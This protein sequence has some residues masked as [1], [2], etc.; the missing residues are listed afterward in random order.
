V[1]TAARTRHHRHTT[2][3]PLPT[4]TAV[5]HLLKPPAPLSRTLCQ[6]PSPCLSTSSI[7]SSFSSLLH[8]TG[9]RLAACCSS[10]LLPGLPITST[11]CCS[12]RR[13]HIFISMDISNL[14]RISRQRMCLPTSASRWHYTA[15]SV[16]LLDS[17]FA[18][19]QDLGS[20]CLAGC[21]LWSH[22]A[23]RALRHKPVHN[24][25]VSP[26]ATCLHS[27]TRVTVQQHLPAAGAP[28]NTPNKPIAIPRKHSKVFH[29]I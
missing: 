7:N 24:G 15:I 20:C 26:C 21:C 11:A 19:C 28:C 13:L 1:G 6:H 22:N 16:A 8:L 10:Q 4:L 3:S 18:C 2:R 14:G 5:L 12:R 29:V 9:R 17:L 25:G 27:N 23:R